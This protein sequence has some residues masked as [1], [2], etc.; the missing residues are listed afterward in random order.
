MAA[1]N[2]PVARVSAIQG[3]AFAKSEDGTMREL[4]VG[5]PVFEGEIL[6][7]PPGSQVELATED[8]HLLILKENEVLTMDAEVVGDAQADASDSALLAAGD[9]TN[10]IIQAINDGGNLDALLEETAAGE[11]AGG[12]DGGSTFVRLLRITEGVDPLSYAFDTPAGTAAAENVNGGL[13]IPAGSESDAPGAADPNNLPVMSAGTGAVTE[14]VG[15]VG[16]NLVTGG[17]LTISDADAGQSAFQPAS[18]TGA[19]GALTLAANGAWTYTAANGQTA[20]QQLGAGDSLSETFT[21]ASVDGTTTTITVTINGTDDV[22]V[23]STGA[24][25][26]TEDVGVVGGNLVTG[27]ALTI[28]DADAGQSAFQP[29]TLN[30]TYGTLTLAADGTWTYTAANGQPA[31]QQL[32][33]GDTLN[34]NF[35]V[36][37]ADGTSTTIAVTINGSNDAPVASSSSIVADEGGGPVALGL[38]AP[39]DIDGDALLITVTGLPTLGQVQLADGTPV[40]DGQT[41]SATELGGLHYVPPAFYNGSD[42][43][44]SFTYTVNDGTVSVPASTAIALVNIG[45]ATLNLAAAANAVE[46]G[47]ITYTATLSSAANTDMSVE[48]S[49]GGTIHIAAGSTSGSVTLAAPGDDVY[50]DAGMVSTTIAGFTGGGIATVTVDPSAALTSVSDTIDTTTLSLTGAA[51]IAE[52]ASGTYTLALTSPAQT[53]VTVTLNYSGSAAHGGD[54]SGVATVTIPAGSSSASFNIAAID[55]ALAEGTES[56]TVS[57]GSASGGNFE[58]LA[59]SGTSASVTTHIV[60]N[61]T[62]TLS[63][64]DTNVEE[65]G[66]AVFTVSLSNPSTSAIS[67]N[68]SLASGTATVG[69]DTASTLEYFNG[70]SWVAVP[71]AGV[72]IAAGETS[73]Q[74]RVATIDDP[75]AEGGETFTLTADVTAGTTANTSAT[76]TATITDETVAGPEDTTT[77]SLSASNSVAEGGQITYTA[78][79]SNPANAPL[80]VTLSNGAV[81]SIAAGATSGSV[82]FDA[83]TDDV[84]V[85][86]GSVSATI[87]TA[88]GGSFEQLVINPAAASTAV[89]DTIDTTTVSLSAS[90]S[91]AEGGQVTYTAS[92]TNAAESAVTVTLSNGAVIHIAAGDSTGSVSVPAPTDDVYVDAGNVSA[93]ITGASGGNFEHLAID[94]TAATTAVTDTTDTTTVSLAASPSVAEGGSIIYTASLTSA[95]ET[96]VTVTLSNGAVINIAAGASTGSVSVPAPADDVYV[97]AGSVSATISGASGGNFEHLVV[98]GAAATTSVS[99]TIDTTTVSLTGAGSVVEG[100]SASYTVSLTSAAQSDVTVNIS[101]SGTA[102]NGADYLGVASVTIPAGSSSASFSLATLDDAFAEGNESIVLNLTSAAGGNFEH[103]A[104]SGS[105]GSLTTTLVDDDGTPSLTVSDVSVSEGDMAVF[106]IGLSNLS[107]TPVTFNPVLTSGT[108]TVGTD[109]ASTLEYFNGTSWVAVTPAGVTIAAGESAVQVR[110][111]TIDDAVAE[112]SETFTLTANVSAGTTANTSATG[113]AT[114]SDEAT[115]DTVLVSIAGPRAVIEGELTG[116]YTVSLDQP[117]VTPVTVTLNYSGTA[118]NGSDYTGV[119]SVT[120]PAGASSATFNLATLDDA[121]AD[122]GETIVVTLGSISGGGFEAIAAHP[123]SNSVTTT[124]NDE[125]VPD[126]T[127]V[128]LSATATVAEGGSIVYTA[129]VSNAVTGSPLVITLDNGQNITIP[130]GSSS[131]QSTPFAVRGDDA[132]VQGNETVTVGI[133]GTTGGNYEALDTSSTADTTVTDDADVTAVTLSAAPSVVE[134]GS[135]VY[136]ATVSNAVT[137]SPLVITL[138]N[139]QTITIPVGSSSA[140]S[141]PFV[142]RGDDA[143]AQGSQ[144]VT[145]SITGATGGNYEALN[146]NSTASTVVADDA[147]ATIVTLTASASRVMEGGSIVYTATVNN[148][149]TGSPLIVTLSNGQ[150]ITIPVGGSSGDSAAFAVRADDAYVQGVQTLNVGISNTSGGN[151]EALNTASTATTTVSDDADVTTVTLTASAGSVVEGGS[152]VYT[153]TVNNA[154]TGSPLVVTLNNGQTITIPVG[155]SSAQS[156]AFAVRGD[157]AYVQGN[158]T[159]TASITGTTGGNYE[160]LNTT[161]TATTLVSDDADATR[162]V[163]TASAD[164]VGEGGSI[165][166]TASVNNPVTGSPLVLTLSNGQTITIPV[167]ATSADSTPFAVRGDDAYVQGNQTLNVGISNTSGG[168]Y[169][170]LNTASTATTTV[171]DDAD[172]TTVTLTAS[173]GSVVEGGSIVYTATVNNPVTGTPLV[174]TLSNNQTITIPVGASSG[175]SAAFAVRADDVYAQGDQIVTTTITATSGGNYEAVATSGSPATTVSDDHDSSTINLSAGPTSLIEGSS[176]SYT[177]TLSSVAQTA[178]TVTLTYSGT[179]T[180]GSDY[181]G[182]TTVTIPAGQSSANFSISTIDDAFAESGEHFTVTI[183]G[184]SGGGFENLVVG[185]NGSLTISIVNEATPDTVLVSIA[186]PGAV[187]EGA[188]TGDYTVSLSQPAVT[189]VTVTL[190]YG[191]TATGGG[192]DYTGVLSVTIPAGASS[193]TFT[194]PTTNDT[195]AEPDETI[196]VSLGTISGGGF[197]AI[198]AHGTDNS[199]TTTIIDN[200]AAPS[201]S[202]N[203]VTV[204]EAAGTA[205]F[206]VSLSAASGQTVT[207]NYATGDGT[208]TAGSDYTATSGTLTFAPGQTALTIT[209]PILNDSI[210]EAN[211]S[212]NV[213]LSAPSNA[214]IGDGTGVGSIVNDDSAPVLDLDADNSTAGGTGYVAHYTENGAGVSIADSDISITDVNGSNLHGATITLTNAQAGDVL[215]VGALPGG[216]AANVAGN[217]ITLSGA[218]SLADYQAA[219]RA[220]TFANGGEN[221]DTTPRTITVSVSDGSNLSNEAIT[222]VNVTAVNDAPVNTVPLDQRTSEDTTRVFSSANG[223]AITVADVDGDTLSTTLSVANGTLTLGS[224]TGVT[225]SGNGTGHV[226]VSGTAAAINAALDGLGFAPTADFNGMT[227]ISVTTSDGTLTDTDSISVNVLPVADIVADVVSTTEDNA[228]SFNV[229]TG[230]NGASADNFENAG[231]AVTS[232]TQ[233]ANGSV[234]FSLNGALVYTPNANFNGT[235]TFTYTVTSGGVTETATVTVNVGAV[236]DAPVLDLDGSAAGSGYTTNYTENAAGVSIAD[237]DV[238][239]TDVDSTNIVSATITLTNARAGDVL[240]VGGLPAGI[241]AS[242]SGSVVTLSGSASLA[243]YQNALRAVTFASTSENPD[244]TARSITVTVN[245]GSANSNTAITTVNVTAVNDAPV[246]QAVTASGNE[247][248]VLAVNLTGTDVDG[249]VASFKLTGLPANGTFYSDAAATNPLTLASVINATGNG[250]TI[251]FKPNPDWNGTN[252]FQ[253]SAT[254]N[255]GLVSTSNATGALTVNPVNDA[256]S[257]TGGSVS[258]TE[259][260]ALVLNWAQFNVTDV[261][262]GPSQSITITSLPA[263]GVLQYSTNGVTWTTISVAGQTILKSNIDLGYLRFVPVANESGIDA[264]GGAGTGNKQADYASFGYQV[265]DGSSANGTGNTATMVIDI[266]PVADAPTLSLVLGSST[267]TQTSIASGVASGYDTFAVSLA[268]A[269]VDSDGSETLSSIRLTGAPTNA[270]FSAGTKQDDGSWIVTAAQLSGLTLRVPTGNAS[271]DLVATVTSSEVSSSSVATTSVSVNVGTD[272]GTIGVAD[273]AVATEAGGTA[274]GTAGTNPTGNVLTNDLIIDTGDSKVVSAVSFG[275]TAGTV[276]SAL[277]GAYGTLTLNADGSYSYVVNNGNSAVQA[278]RTASSTLTETFTY[279][280]TD[281]NGTGSSSTTLTV[282]IQGANDAPVAVADTNVVTRTGSSQQTISTTVATGVLANDSDVD[283]GDSERVSAITK[284]AT[285]QTI[286]SGGST[287]ITGTY[288]NLTIYSDG[289]YTYTTTG[290]RPS[291]DVQD[292]FTYTVRDTAGLTS[293]ATLTINVDRANTAPI[294]EAGAVTGIEDTPLVFTWANFNVSDADGV[295]SS[296]GVNIRS[297]PTD[298][299]LQ[300][301]TDGVTW[302]TITSTDTTVLKSAIDAGLFRFVPDA[303]ESGSNDYVT[304]GTGNMRTDYASFSY[305]GTDGSLNSGN[306]TMT[307]DIKPVADDAKITVG[308]VSVIDGTVKINTPPDSQGLTVRQYTAIGNISTTTVDTDAEV[309]SLLTLLDANTPGSTSISTAPQNYNTTNGSEPSGIP[310]DGAYRIT[311]LVYMEAGHSYTFSSY[312]DDTGLL[313]IGGTVVLAKSYNSWGNI[314]ATT[315]VPTVS[316]Y[317]TLDW[318]VYNGDNIGALKP[319]LSVERRNRARAD[320]EQLQAIQLG[321]LARCAGRCQRARRIHHRGR[322]ERLLPGRRQQ[323][324]GYDDQAVADRGQ[325][326]RYRRFGNARQRRRAKPA[327]R[328]DADRRYAQLHGDG[329]QYI[330]KHHRVDAGYVEHHPAKGLLRQLLAESGGDDQGNGDRRD[331]DE[332]HGDR[333][334]GRRCSRCADGR[335]RCRPPDR[336]LRHLPGQ[337]QCARQRQ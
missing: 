150:T 208:A 193:A 101:Y 265:A 82:H 282:T 13:G 252:T 88:V 104:I 250:A 204:N 315:Y 183:G 14:D 187:T 163:L 113:T 20:I 245:D 288:G 238:A 325:P 59:I 201:L 169:E 165:V 131:A 248:T 5:D 243:D 44:G 202:I 63:V 285:T 259:D 130:V 207:V 58:D 25:F 107:A 279:T 195:M 205:T 99:D 120:I 251:Y 134:G 191:G 103:L 312:M 299:V 236:N 114:I 93:T 109:T 106:T 273:T 213:T 50:L 233:G 216:I 65:G 139:G 228:V 300:T 156:A 337:R 188:T 240:A 229:L 235:D 84:Y 232:V 61:D 267:F 147:D 170:A 227:T 305:R 271:F 269:L 328:N 306:V 32:G 53:D 3:T 255:N 116:D 34:E 55:D 137:G 9:D 162:V 275:G 309:R 302:T 4:K 222:T 262:G 323:R 7:A 78:L 52:G 125:A 95:A 247:D 322:L 226:V 146:V 217:V 86:A 241:S 129:T 87:A 182:V 200:D 266:T 100:G 45:S 47:T 304:S 149:V 121:L 51:S 10:R 23:M 102:A 148:P 89:T 40:S 310:T 192:S 244:T 314:T 73:V 329:R 317:Y 81:I 161:S 297:L 105:A 286:S 281:G 181:T 321:R 318:A 119:V 313:V 320:D 157:D 319:Y 39:T 283:S 289:H 335:G 28:S 257:T 57:I 167:G 223:N 141:T 158:Q 26:V 249:T 179:A 60:D 316:G 209:V 142:V 246:P 77:V 258:G 123:A 176:G 164:S 330:R 144:T 159:V 54:Y 336:G 98:N 74:V 186:G 301:S 253:Y 8:G 171:S 29:A 294:A 97:D 145:A 153:A 333:H 220:I 136:T 152:I 46:G 219:I 6:V 177:L 43:V 291:A 70:T 67:F 295:G 15:V 215:A 122:S 155:S 292:V 203:D 30:G 66:Y 263:N 231:R 115:P 274:N 184:T 199:V 284:G 1:N 128:S 33:V 261:D 327:G 154:V 224:I 85:N 303:N 212:F 174:V 234:T 71:P 230:T 117:A 270:I 296:L 172:V 214:T 126:V 17:T 197:E 12:S 277:A 90:N 94:P 31:I 293:T 334:T 135:I 324:R 140:Q 287:T 37:S 173:A 239:I 190:N 38:A 225:V 311:G 18:L 278:L 307:V 332:Q 272:H 111:A 36:L 175:N 280:T 308:G 133:T 189:A 218:G 112:G 290:S 138:D 68:P 22:P 92:L 268:S 80:T 221:P 27:G 41:L 48:L 64:T 21:V 49:N 242:I 166:Y 24:G 76:G 254:D 124:I 198:A 276:G 185:G 62:P 256:P 75:I 127:T 56:F 194:L 11:A 298:G 16:G 110:V 211:E 91:V 210:V 2:I 331:G 96:P 151:Y 260:Q 132:Y 178:V 206:T 143:Y 83:P 180:D 118:T 196:V 35:T 42:P 160:V 264:Y 19:Y 69:T 108:A 79:L 326:V 72:T 237:T 168:N